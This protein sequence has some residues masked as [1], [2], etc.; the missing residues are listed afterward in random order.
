MRTKYS[1]WYGVRGV[2]FIWHGAWNDPELSYK[3]IT[4][5]YTDVED[6]FWSVFKEE[7][8]GMSGKELDENFPA[9]LR[10]NAWEVKQFFFDSVAV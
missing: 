3:G 4:L 6:Y 7:N 8:P 10:K 5:N 2:R 9:W 1:Y